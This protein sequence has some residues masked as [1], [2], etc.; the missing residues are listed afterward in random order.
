M[1]PHVRAFNRLR[2]NSS[3]QI[4]ESRLNIVWDVR[5]RLLWEME[6]EKAAPTA[7]KD[8]HIFHD[9]MCNNNNSILY[10]LFA[11]S[12]AIIMILKGSYDGCW[13]KEIGF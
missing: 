3:L 4:L 10:Y 6:N 12:T 8:K 11:E 5:C 9:E 13:I 1:D 2:W 7:T